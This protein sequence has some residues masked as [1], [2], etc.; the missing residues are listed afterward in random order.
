MAR[1]RKPAPQAAKTMQVRYPDEGAIEE[2]R[3][4]WYDVPATVADKRGWLESQYREEMARALADQEK[5][6]REQQVL[7]DRIAQQQRL[8]EQLPSRVD[9]LELENA[10]LRAELQQVQAQLAHL[11]ETKLLEINQN[12]AELMGR[13]YD[14]GQQVMAQ[15]ETT[16]QLQQSNAESLERW[17]EL[18]QQTLDVSRNQLDFW[19]Q[20]QAAAGQQ[21]QQREDQ[22]ALEQEHSRKLTEQIGENWEL[23]DAARKLNATSVK[24]Q[25]E[26]FKAAVTKTQNQLTEEFVEMLNLGLTALGLTEG[27]PEH[28]GAEHRDESPPS[29]S[30]G[31]PEDPLLLRSDAEESRCLGPRR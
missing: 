24:K 5:A 1:Q 11:D 18:K 2:M 10:E 21:I 27:R 13:S 15:T 16:R 30:A 8:G 19:N 20:A 9:A 22:I 26:A 29:R 6:E 14:M 28:G 7:N 12:T 25:N 23:V 4:R 3:G 17:A 31:H